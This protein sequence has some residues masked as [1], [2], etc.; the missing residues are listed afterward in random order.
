MPVFTLPFTL[1]TMVMINVSEARGLLYRVEDMS[2]PEK[3]A[4][5][6]HTRIRVKSGDENDVSE[7]FVCCKTPN[8]LVIT[9]K[10]G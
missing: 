4:Y 6:W 3:Q 10:I 2:Y 5:Q 7:D 9:K 8:Y 1:V